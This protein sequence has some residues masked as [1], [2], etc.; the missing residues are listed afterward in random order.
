[1]KISQKLAIIIAVSLVILC[2]S[3]IYL[4]NSAMKS[5]SD[6]T[7]VSI[8]KL[9]LDDA[10]K[11]AQSVVYSVNHMTDQLYLDLKSKGISKEVSYNNTIKYL[12]NMDLHNKLVNFFAMDEDGT[13]LVH[14]VQARVGKNHIND[15]DIYGKYFIQDLIKSSAN[16]DGGYVKTKFFDSMINKERNVL[17]Y[18]QKDIGMG[19]IYACTVDLDEGMKEIQKINDDMNSHINEFGIKFITYAVIIGII[20]LAILIFFVLFQISKPLNYLTSRA[21]ELS[22]GDGDL[23]QKLPINGKDEIAATSKA[24]NDFIEKVRLLIVDAKNISSENA[25][26]ANE[27]S[28]SSLNT[29]QSV[30][31]SSVIVRD[32]ANKGD[33][34][35]STLAIGVKAA[36]DGKNQLVNA[37]KYINDVNKSI[38]ELN[39]KIMQSANLEAEVSDKIVRLS[40]DADNVKSILEMINDVADQTNLLALNAAIEAARAGEHGRGFAVV[41][42]EVRKLAERTQH[43]LVEI[44]ATISV[45]TQG[46]EDASGQMSL[47]A[48]SIGELTKLADNTQK[49][50]NDMNEAMNNV[51]GISNQTVDDYIITSK[52]MDDILSGVNNINKI[53]HENARSVEEIAGAANHLSNITEKLNSKLNEFRT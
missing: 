2:S 28:Q 52:V 21:T 23:T 19:I 20:I 18:A 35:N 10:L 50:M 7:D 48:K 13:Y 11:T 43:S 45:I 33:S 34:A 16:P 15:K 22:S 30:E 1:M 37:L 47:N 17:I 8:E 39:T 25:S 4:S 9:V 14:Y 26:V 40:Q 42:D 38:S 41:A 44:N 51:I 31:Q 24:I 53:T 12:S 5:I 49:T 46:I 36:E 3:M 6:D 32:V 29:G 27:L